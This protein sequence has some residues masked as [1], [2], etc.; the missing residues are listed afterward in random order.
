M[1]FAIVFVSIMASMIMSGCS[2]VINGTKQDV[3][4]TSFPPGLKAQIQ[5]KECITPCTLKDVSRRSDFLTIYGL[6]NF[7]I[8]FELEK[9]FNGW[10]VLG[11]NLLDP[12]AILI[13]VA[14]GSTHT[15]EP[16]S[17]TMK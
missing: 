6:G 11:G 16:V 15:I 3:S 17:I 13:D 4:I 5:T 9:T 14:A 1:K 2:T 8:Q 7:P 10:A 12:A